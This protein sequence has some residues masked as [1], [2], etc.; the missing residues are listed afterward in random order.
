MGRRRGTSTFPV[1]R[2]KKIM[3][4]DE[5]VG[6]IATATPV[7]VAKALECLME[8]LLRDAAT[9]AIKRRTKTVTPQHLKHSVAAEAHFDF[10]RPTLKAVPALDANTKDGPAAPARRGKRP[11]ATPSPTPG[12][13]ARAHASSPTRKNTRRYRTSTCDRP[14]RSTSRCST[15]QSAFAFCPPRVR[16]RSRRRPQVRRPSHRPSPSRTVCVTTMET[17]TITT[18]TSTTPRLR[19]RLR[20]AS[21]HCAS[22]TRRCSPSSSAISAC[23]HR[24]DVRHADAHSMPR[25]LSACARHLSNIPPAAIWRGV[26][27]CR[28]TAETLTFGLLASAAR[29]KQNCSPLKPED[30]RRNDEAF[31]K[32]L[33]EVPALFHVRRNRTHRLPQPVQSR[34]LP[35][36]ADR[37]KL[38]KREQEDVHFE[39]E[40][41]VGTT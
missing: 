31:V 25:G 10:L 24:R 17:M 40:D 12:A 34:R 38:F 35:H 16:S 8:D 11:R 1:A 36:H 27:G 33:H 2:I 15:M 6:K 14:P 23:L 21:Q 7:L 32:S 26:P 19:S 22:T 41:L 20:R 9:V 37:R 29:K 18:A 4:A 13:Q 39:S 30:G 5:D 28:L 3:Q